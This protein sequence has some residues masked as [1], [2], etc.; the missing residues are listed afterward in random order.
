MTVLLPPAFEMLTDLGTVTVCRLDAAIDYAAA[1][2]AS[3]NAALREIA[4]PPPVLQTKPIHQ[5]RAFGCSDWYDG[6]PDTT[7]TGP[8]ETRTL[9]SAADCAALREV[10][11]GAAAADEFLDSPEAIYRLARMARAALKTAEAALADIGDSDREPGDDLAWC[12]R[13]AA[14]ALPAVRAAL[15]QK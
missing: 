1:V 6:Y 7:I 15:G 10:V 2:S 3:D 12:E 14:Q 9:V 5:F 4:A 13:R 8:Y 11:E